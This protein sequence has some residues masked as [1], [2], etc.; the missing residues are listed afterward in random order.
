M[1]AGAS[2]IVTSFDSA[3]GEF[4]VA[5]QNL[6][7]AAKNIID[8]RVNQ[9]SMR[10]ALEQR[11]YAVHIVT[12]TTLVE[13]TVPVEPTQNPQDRQRR[14]EDQQSRRDKESRRG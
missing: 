7:Q 5:F 14:E 10:A 2:L 8:M 9:E 1:F 3:K 4:N 6:T 12:A 13:N 11:G